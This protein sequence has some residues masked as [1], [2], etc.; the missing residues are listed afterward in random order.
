MQPTDAA[1]AQPGAR[2]MRHHEEVPTVA[3]IVANISDDVLVAA[4]S[5]RE[6]IDRPGV[7]T[8][9]GK[10]PAHYAGA[11]APDQSAAHVDHLHQIAPVAGSDTERRLTRL[12]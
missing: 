7:V 12:F 5:G 9:G 10:G 8:H 2:W 4:I 11:L 1:V 6:E 3:E